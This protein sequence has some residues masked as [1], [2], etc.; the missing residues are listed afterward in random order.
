M[1]VVDHGGVQHAVFTGLADAGDAQQRVLQAG[2]EDFLGLP[3]ALAPEV[4]G[5]A[6]LGGVVVDVEVDRLGR[7]AFKNDHVPAGHLELGAPVA[8][9][10]RAG[11]GAGERA[12]GDDGVAPAGGGHG[13]GQRAGGPD[14]L[15]VGRQRIDLGVDFADQVLAAEA[16]RTEVG[17]GPLHVQRFGLHGARGQVDAEDFSS[18]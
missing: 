10:V 7:L 3:H 15:V 9:R 13:A 1:Q 18:P 6:Q 4:A 17:A 5:I 14:D 16:A 2:L 11:D 12:L 8:A